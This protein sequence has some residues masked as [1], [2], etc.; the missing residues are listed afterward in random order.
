LPRNPEPDGHVS[1]SD[2]D[3]LRREQLLDEFNERLRRGELPRVEEYTRRHP[4]LAAEL[5]DVLP[6]LRVLEDAAVESSVPS[7]SSFE[8]LSVEVVDEGRALATIGCGERS[9][10]AA[11][12]SSGRPSSCRST[13]VWH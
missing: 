10:A 3:T 9:V 6:S 11:W 8:A 12:A 2:S 4:E 7:T 1:D 13:D 5:R